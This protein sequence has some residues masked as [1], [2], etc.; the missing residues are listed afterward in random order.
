MSASDDRVQQESRHPFSLPSDALLIEKMADALSVCS[1][2]L[3]GRDQMIDATDRPGFV[4]Q[5]S[6]LTKMVDEAM[7]AWRRWEFG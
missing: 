6:P 5:K 7:D 2:M 1:E 3:N 4:S